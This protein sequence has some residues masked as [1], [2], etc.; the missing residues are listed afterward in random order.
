MNSLS[1]LE[2]HLL[3]AM[4]SLSDRFFQRSVIYVCEHSKE[5]AMGIIIN[6]PSTMTFRELINQT[7]EHAIVDDNKSEQIVLC[8]G[9]VNQDRGFILH[10]TQQGWSSSM[11]VS[12]RIM[13]TTSKD[14]LT[15]IGNDLGPKKS[16]VALGY[17]GWESGQLEQEIQENAWL[18]VEADDDLLFDTPIHSKW[19]SA[20]NKLGVDVWQL[21]PEAGHA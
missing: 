8:G 7:D 15:V 6:Q 4:P 3:I 16:L 18:V 14:I 1:S 21:T 11:V 19:Q 13:V 2:N 5:G 17:A 20:V 12:P 9:P 10:H